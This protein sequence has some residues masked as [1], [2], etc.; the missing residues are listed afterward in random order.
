MLTNMNNEL[1]NPVERHYGVLIAEDSEDD[2]FLIRKAVGIA[3]SLQ[4]IA[5]VPDGAGVVAYLRGEGEFGDRQRFPIPDLLLL[6]L[7]MPRMDGFEVLEWIR[8]QRPRDVIVVVLTDSLRPEHLKRAL[9]LGA[10]RFQVK[11]KSIADRN[12]MILALEQYLHRNI[13]PAHFS[14]SRSPGSVA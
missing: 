9:E 11:P 6:D 10:H 4:I 7:N 2:R 13:A 12:S 8:T 14:A 1:N 3:P 5:E